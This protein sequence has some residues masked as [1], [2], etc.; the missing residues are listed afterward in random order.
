[1]AGSIGQKGRADALQGTLKGPEG[2]HHRAGAI[3]PNP[4]APVGLDD[5]IPAVA[6]VAVVDDHI[7]IAILG[8]LDQP[9]PIPR[10]D[11]PALERRLCRPALQL[12]E[13]GEIK[14]IRWEGADLCG[15]GNYAESF[16]M[17]TN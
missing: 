2:G 10:L 11:I 13:C 7:L 8:A 1:V 6:R 5:K 14:P 12:D 17:G 3:H 16:W 9:I 15:V 4:P